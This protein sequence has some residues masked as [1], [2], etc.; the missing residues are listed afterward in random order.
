[1]DRNQMQ[2]SLFSFQFI[3]GLFSPT[4]SIVTHADSAEDKGVASKGLVMM[5]VGKTSLNVWSSLPS[6]SCI[7]TDQ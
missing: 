3:P 6:L 5:L 2:R 4:V 1:M 7:L